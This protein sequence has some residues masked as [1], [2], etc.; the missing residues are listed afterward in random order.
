MACSDERVLSV[1]SRRVDV[2][3]LYVSALE[4]VTTCPENVLTHVGM[5]GALPNKLPIRLLWLEAIGAIFGGGYPV[6]RALIYAVISDV[7]SPD[8]R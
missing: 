6:A 4:L 7:T 1:G 3:R 8:A 5:L 2:C